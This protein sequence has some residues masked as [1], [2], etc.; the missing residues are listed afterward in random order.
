MRADWIIILANG[1]SLCALLGILYF[2][3]R[4]DWSA[5]RAPLL[6]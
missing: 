5:N 4:E 2:K 3:I 6:R 1:V